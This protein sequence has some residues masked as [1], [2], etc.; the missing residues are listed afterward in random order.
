MERVVE[1]KEYDPHNTADKQPNIQYAVRYTTDL[2]IE[3]NKGLL[4]RFRNPAIP[5][6]TRKN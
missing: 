2:I 1:K 4:P 5:A 3:V 6:T